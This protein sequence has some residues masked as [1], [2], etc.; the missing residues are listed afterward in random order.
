[1]TFLLTN[2][3]YRAHIVT[4]AELEPVAEEQEQVRLWRLTALKRAGYEDEAAQ[5]L[6]RRHDVDL[7]HAVDL[8]RRGC[9]TETAL[10]ILI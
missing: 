10:R 8:V 3:L 7:H 9:P 6:A 1:L 4:T 2:P 5:V